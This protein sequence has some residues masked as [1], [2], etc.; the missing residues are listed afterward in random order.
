VPSRDD[1]IAGLEQAIVHLLETGTE[2]L[3]D[4]IHAACCLAGAAVA[5]AAG[6]APV[7]RSGVA[8][9]ALVRR[10]QRS[11]HFDA[12]AAFL[13]DGLASPPTAATAITE[14]A[15]SSTSSD[16][17][18]PDASQRPSDSID[19]TTRRLFDLIISDEEIYES[20]L[21]V[22]LAW[23][24]TWG[25]VEL[26]RELEQHAEALRDKAEP[27]SAEADAWSAVGPLQVVWWWYLP[28]MLLHG[29]AEAANDTALL[30]RLKQ[31]HERLVDEG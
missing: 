9:Q 23:P 13:L 11:Q 5:R 4:D 24:E 14:A 16:D 2:T 19:P 12:F 28:F 3:A 31:E 10:D 25:V 7:M 8:A 1:A 20:F 6:G 29:Y 30:A 18:T 15:P 21:A 22:A 26:G 27:G 17:E